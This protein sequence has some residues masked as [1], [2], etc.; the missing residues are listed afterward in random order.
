MHPRLLLLLCRYN[1]AQMSG[2]PTALL[3]YHCPLHLSEFLTLYILSV[4]V[5][6]YSI[7][8]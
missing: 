4:L 1:E 3:H 5:R 6:S 2:S 7:L 8:Y